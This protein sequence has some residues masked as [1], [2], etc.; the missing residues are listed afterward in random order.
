MMKYN[1][2]YCDHCGEAIYKRKLARKTHV[3]NINI[4]IY[5]YPENIQKWISVKRNKQFQD[6][7]YNCYNKY[8]KG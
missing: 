7:C 6:Y 5:D 1:T 3:G 8:I 4:T 2:G